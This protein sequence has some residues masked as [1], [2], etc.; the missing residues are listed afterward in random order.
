M[1]STPVIEATLRAI[2]TAQRD[3]ERWSGGDWLWAAP[4]Y[5]ATTAIAR[6]LHRLD[7][8]RY[9][10]MEG[11]VRQ[12]MENAGGN[13]VGRP[14]S[15]LNLEGWFDVVA[16]NTRGPRGLI[17][18]KTTVSGYSQLAGD[19]QKLK[20]ALAKAQDIRWG[21]VAYFVSLAHGVHKDAKARVVTRTAE[22]ARRATEEMSNE[23]AV[24]RHTDRVRVTPGGAWTAEELEI[25]RVS[26]PMGTRPR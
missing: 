7:Q 4:E 15:R 6:A 8:V 19:V 24:T 10:T 20:T 14:N 3:Y 22:I 17:E 21:L 1:K 23:S 9:V 5:M 25:R 18:A 12:A 2:A 16:W 26:K 11:N 13:L